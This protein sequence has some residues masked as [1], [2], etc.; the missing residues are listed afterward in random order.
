MLAVGCYPSS[1][2]PCCCGGPVETAEGF[3]EIQHLHTVWHLE[4]SAPDEPTMPTLHTHNLLPSSWHTNDTR[5]EQLHMLCIMTGLCQLLCQVPAWLWAVE[6]SVMRMTHCSC[7]MGSGDLGPCRTCG[8]EG[9]QYDVRH[10]PSH[11]DSHP[12][13]TALGFP[14]KLCC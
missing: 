13:S 6:C 9:K 2:V 8:H 10:P 11:P 5:Q 3:C 14:V 7:W 12:I 1:M 4:V